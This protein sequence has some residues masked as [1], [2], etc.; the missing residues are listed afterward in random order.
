VRLPLALLGA[1]VLAL[2]TGAG[3]LVANV[4]D[5]YG[6]PRAISSTAGL[7]VFRDAAGNLASYLP[8]EPGPALT[9]VGFGVVLVPIALAVAA[10]RWRARV[11]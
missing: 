3:M 9:L 8:F 6:R 4:V 11:Y 2:A 1:A 5:W 7:P 10:A